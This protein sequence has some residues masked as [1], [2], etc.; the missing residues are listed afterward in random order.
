MKRSIPAFL[1]TSE[2]LTRANAE[3]R[4]CLPSWFPCL[5][6]H[7]CM[8]PF[9]AHHGQLQIANFEPGDRWQSGFGDVTSSHKDAYF[10]L[11][12]H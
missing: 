7:G 5:K 12:Y 9:R 11:T 4:V 10:G 1:Q 8:P 6:P 3:Y 2:A